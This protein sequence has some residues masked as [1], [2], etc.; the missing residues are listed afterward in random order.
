MIFHRSV[1]IVS[2]NCS[3]IRITSWGNT[4]GTM[5]HGYK[6]GGGHRHGYG[7]RQ[8]LEN[9]KI[10]TWTQQGTQQFFEL[11]NLH[12]NHYIIQLRLLLNA[13]STSGG[14][15]KHFILHFCPKTFEAIINTLHRKASKDYTNHHAESRVCPL[16]VPPQKIYRLTGQATWHVSCAWRVRQRYSVYR[17]EC[18]CFLNLDKN[19]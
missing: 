9:I 16:Q 12:Y 3:L 13:L 2:H 8:F 5:Q 19:L 6:H 10:R 18:R 7:T 11:C 17:M 15:Y 14:L 4:H 1:I